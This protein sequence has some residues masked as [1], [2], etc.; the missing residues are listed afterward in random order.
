[1]PQ[2]RA[3]VVALALIAV[4]ASAGL[5]PARAQSPAPT[6]TNAQRAALDLVVRAVNAGAAGP[7]APATWQSHVLRA[8][9]GSHYVALRALAPSLP[10]PTGPVVLYVRLATRLPAA[11]TASAERSAV[12]EWL[13]GQR[14]DPLPMR[15]GG[16]MSVPRGEMP[17][18]GAA[19]GRDPAAES[20]AALRLLT[21]ERERAARRREDEQAARKA[22]LESATRG[23]TFEMMP[24]EDFDVAAQL[25]A[26]PG[27]GVDL[28]RS[29][30]AG[31]GD[32]DLFVG[33]TTATR[34]RNTP[35]TV[36]VVRHRLVLPAAPADFA[37]SDLVLADEVHAT[38]ASYRPD[39]QNA[40]PYAMGAL[41]ATPAPD[42]RFFVDGRLSVLMQVIN[43]SADDA[44]KPDVRVTFAVTR[45]D[46]VRE[47]AVG[48]LPQQR[49]SS[50]TLPADFSI[51]RGHP[52]FVAVQAS[53]ARFSRG[54]YRLTVSAIDERSGRQATREAPF[55]VAGTPHSL[56]RE[57]PTPGQAFRRE[58]L[59]TPPLLSMML[60]GLTPAEPSA[61]LQ[62]MLDAA[63]AGRYADLVREAPVEP[64]ERATA[65]ALRALGLYALGDSP[66]SVAVQLQQALAQ[67]VPPAPILLLVGAT[68]ALG[69]S[70]KAAVASWNDARDG[71]VDD[72][73]IASLL[74]DA[75]LRLGDV[76]RATAMARAALDAQ[77]GNLA[78]A[79]RPGRRQH[80]R[81]A[82]CRGGPGAR[83][84]PGRGR[85]PRHG[86]SHRARALR[87][88]RGP[89]GAGQ[90]AVGRDASADARAAIRRGWRPLRRAGHR[91]AGRDGR[92]CR[93]RPASRT[94]S[95]T[96]SAA[97]RPAGAPGPAASASRPCATTR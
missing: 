79:S 35:A 25:S 92:T 40:H 22:A 60:R 81:R 68:Q 52:L 2:P 28:R 47:I 63:A 96:T 34:A 85:R 71:S 12:H 70:D 59:L 82:V 73:G 74:V 16:S 50:A 62:R 65:Q 88:V 41:E 1:M 84:P 46:G 57:A 31:P 77:P 67:G 94:L 51:T 26:A 6:L 89:V 32:Y 76:A 45:L 58:A 29:L 97:A 56:L 36:H 83:R 49:H 72:T 24:F 54:R 37:L 64:G 33:W 55:D 9:D 86:V 93:R 44:G 11:A 87:R 8:S 48:S 13:Q 30:T 43:P 80:R 42:H 38:S 18:G 91:V 69:G 4:L 23:R 19:L 21:L 7:V 39:Q 95:V 78:A 17:V 75:Y 10:A 20:V 61:M 53:L 14:S 90:H 66:R 3:F 27:G 15:V 5:G